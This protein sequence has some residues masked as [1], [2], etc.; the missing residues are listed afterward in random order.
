MIA[1]W[2]ADKQHHRWTCTRC[3]AATEVGRLDWRRSAGIGRFFVQI[4]DVF[5]EEAVPLHR[6]LD[7]LAEAGCGAWRYFYHQAP[8][9]GDH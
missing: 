2:E 8:A 7:E 4:L 9:S 6:L 1:A 5:P 3:G